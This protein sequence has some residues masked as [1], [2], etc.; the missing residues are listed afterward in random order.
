MKIIKRWLE[1]FQG[2][3][4]EITCFGSNDIRKFFDLEQDYVNWKE[5]E[6]FNHKFPVFF[7]FVFKCKMI[8]IFL[9]LL[10]I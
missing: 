8:K 10:N 2:T 9:W 3:V 5:N 7:S 1:S 6:K 4:I